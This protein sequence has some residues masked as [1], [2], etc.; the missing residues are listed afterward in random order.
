VL[1]INKLGEIH[2]FLLGLLEYLTDPFIFVWLLI[3]NVINYL[4][5]FL[6]T[7]FSQPHKSLI[8]RFTYKYLLFNLLTSPIQQKQNT[9]FE[10]SQ[11][12]EKD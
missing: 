5:A 2:S 4:K 1:A 6:V 12:A 3:F 10:N 8:I 7:N 11:G 9:H